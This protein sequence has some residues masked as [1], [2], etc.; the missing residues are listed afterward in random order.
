MFPGLQERAKK[1]LD[2]KSEIPRDVFVTA[3]ATPERHHA[4]SRSAV[5]QVAEP[6]L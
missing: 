4:V 6:L 2:A 3:M 1:E 5:M